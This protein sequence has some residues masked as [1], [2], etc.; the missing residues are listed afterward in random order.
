MRK[1]SSL[2]RDSSGIFCYFLLIIF[3]NF[4]HYR[5]QSLG[6]WGEKWLKTVMEFGPLRNTDYPRKYI[7]NLTE[8]V[9]NTAAI[10][11][12]NLII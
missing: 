3:F 2:K 11:Y 8:N 4:R 12:G 7:G 5:D 9:V 10:V 1:S 6:E